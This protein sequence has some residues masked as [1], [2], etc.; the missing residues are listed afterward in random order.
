MRTL[1][2]GA[3]K[4]FFRWAFEYARFGTLLDASFFSIQTPRE[5]RRGISGTT[6]KASESQTN[7]Q[8]QPLPP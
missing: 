5:T 1:R 7:N 3:S 8:Q 6:A 2:K 4:V